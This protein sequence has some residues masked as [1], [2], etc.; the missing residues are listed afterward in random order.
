M[1]RERGPAGREDCLAGRRVRPRTP[2][3]GRPG[4]RGGPGAVDDEPGLAQ[5]PY[6]P[7][8]STM[9]TDNQ[10]AAARRNVKRAQE[11]A[12]RANPEA[13]ARP[14]L[15][16]T[17]GAGRARFGIKAARGWARKSGGARSR[18]PVSPG[19]APAV[20]ATKEPRCR[21]QR[22]PMSAQIADLP[23]RAD[24]ARGE[25]PAC[26]RRVRP[27]GRPAARRD[28]RGPSARSAVNASSS[29]SLAMH[30]RA[31]TGYT[32][33]RRAVPRSIPALGGG[34]S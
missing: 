10:R 18:E 21:R 28:R 11:G 26:I 7:G 25:H 24:A 27:R 3:T 4:Y 5:R 17:R 8:G 16:G 15:E 20:I 6:G 2:R 23:R 34:G 19:R 30:D 13:P 31:K 22:S 9:A 32:D 14:D 1:L 33:L 29:C 12:Q